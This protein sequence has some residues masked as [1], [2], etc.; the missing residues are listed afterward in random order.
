MY[1]PSLLPVLRSGHVKAFAPIAEEGLV[2][3]IAR[4]LPEHL[5]AILGHGR[6]QLPP[7]CPSFQTMQ[8]PGMN[9]VID[10][11]LFGS[12]AEFDSTLDH[13]L[14]EFS[15]ELICLAGFVRVL[16]S[17]FLRK[18]RGKIL[19][20]SPSLLPLMKDGNAPQEPL[21]GG[22]KV[23]GCTVHFVLESPGPGPAIHRES[24]AVRAGDSAELLSE[25][26]RDA[27]SRALPTALQLVA[28]GAVSLAPD[29]TVCWKR[30]SR[31]AALPGEKGGCDSPPA[32]PESQER[33]GL[34]AGQ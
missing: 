34:R 28:S 23:T 1:S 27:E 11:K 13:V 32:A 21:Q 6:V 5:S 18:W 20:A 12:R 26:V 31:A 4:I 2:G 30:E 17:P 16:S 25:R 9:E 14:E 10:P 19:S 24:V 15:V 29:G 7:H 22:F 3:G 33:D 8:W